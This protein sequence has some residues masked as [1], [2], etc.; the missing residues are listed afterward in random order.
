MFMNIKIRATHTVAV[1]V[2]LFWSSSS[3]SSSY[4]SH[5]FR[6]AEIPEDERDLEIRK[7][8]RTR[9]F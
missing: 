9:R 5:K 2:Y 6:P 4:T 8:A 3:S 7:N 1:V